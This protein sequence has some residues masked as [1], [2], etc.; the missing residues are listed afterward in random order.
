MLVQQCYKF[1][2]YCDSILHLHQCFAIW[3][4]LVHKCGCVCSCTRAWCSV[5]MSC[6]LLDKC[7]LVQVPWHTITGH[8]V[9]HALL[10]TLYCTHYCTHCTACTIAHIVLHALLHTLYCTHYCTHCT[11]RTIAHT[12]LH[13]LLHYCTH[14]TPR[15]TALLH[16]L[17]STP[18][19]NWHTHNCTH[20]CA[21]YSTP[22]TKL[23]ASFRKWMK[24]LLLLIRTG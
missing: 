13:A 6:G 1:M 4:S 20:S 2:V 14:C 7:S 19:F 8:I 21:H 18:L 16:T 12:V 23:D 17:Y 3:C 22:T 5:P 10:H 9:L 24:K 11:A 15:V